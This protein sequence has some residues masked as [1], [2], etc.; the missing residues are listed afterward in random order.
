MTV[1][2]ASALYTEVP[3]QQRLVQ[4]AQQKR[5]AD[6][7]PVIDAGMG[8]VELLTRQDVRQRVA[9][10]LACAQLSLGRRFHRSQE[11]PSPRRVKD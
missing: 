7:H 10:K 9:D 4:R 5:Q 6:I 11:G 3:A 2:N 1:I 8:T